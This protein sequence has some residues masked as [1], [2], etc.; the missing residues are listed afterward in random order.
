MELSK[1]RIVISS[2]ILGV[3]NGILFL[4]LTDNYFEMGM[5]ELEIQWVTLPFLIPLLATLV[6]FFLDGEPLI[7]TKLQNSAL[8]FALCA[9]G[10]WIPLVFAMLIGSIRM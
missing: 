9:I 8:F 2:L 1:K 10:T 4:F 6:I 5:F 3:V 7:K